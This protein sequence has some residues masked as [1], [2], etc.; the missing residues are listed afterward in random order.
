V[1]SAETY[2]L[3]QNLLVNSS[4]SEEMTHTN[5]SV[6]GQQPIPDKIIADAVEALIGLYLKVCY[7]TELSI[8][9]VSYRK[10]VVIFF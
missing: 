4:E 3:L 2:Q 8:I 10:S 6:L 9:L 1:L 5:L 7:D